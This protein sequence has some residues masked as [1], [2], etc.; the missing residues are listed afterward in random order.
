MDIKYYKV[1]DSNKRFIRKIQIKDELQEDNFLKGVTCFIV[2]KKGEVLIEERA[3][4]SKLMPGQLDLCSGHVDEEETYTQAMIREYRE[5]L[6]SASKDEQEKATME[7][8]NKLKPIKE[9]DLIFKNKGKTRNFFIKFY[10]LMTD[11]TNI[12]IQEDEIKN[13][14]WVPMQ[15]CFELIRNG[16]T[17]FPY[18]SRYEEIF[19]KVEDI[20]KGIGSKKDNNITR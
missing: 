9:L 8:I 16:K 1:Y 17:K 15:E 10:A 14:T 19:K 6:H 13:I 20:Y 5:E 4:K 12:H 7:A 2:N 11:N 3:S 18:D